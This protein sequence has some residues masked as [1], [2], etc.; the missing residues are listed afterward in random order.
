MK[1]EVCVSVIM[2]TYNNSGFIGDAIESV[3]V[4]SYPHFELIVVD[5]CSTDNTEEVLASIKDKRVKVYKLSENFGLPSKVRNYGINCSKG[6]FIAFLDSDDQW[7]STKLEKQMAYM[8]RAP[9]LA[10]IYTGGEWITREGI[11]FKRVL[12]RYKSGRILTNQLIKY[13]INNQGVLAKKQ[14]LEEFGL[15][16]ESIKIGEDYNLYMKI[17]HKYKVGVISDSLFSY[18]KYSDSI[19]GKNKYDTKGLEVTLKYLRAEGVPWIKLIFLIVRI[20][21]IKIKAIICP[22]VSPQ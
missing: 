2:P 11:S 13:E 9:E 7:H 22:V 21:S 8:A 3:L 10:M 16:D 5:D 20:H 1:S 17:L 19:S 15:F 6:H 18:R 4:Q 12:P 14:A